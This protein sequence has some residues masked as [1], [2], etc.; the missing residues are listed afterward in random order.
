MH[1]RVALDTT[2]RPSQA[3]ICRLA[4]SGESA[5]RI[6]KEFGGIVCE[7]DETSTYS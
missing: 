6:R 7:T 5:F 1:R 2:V 4:M 3:R